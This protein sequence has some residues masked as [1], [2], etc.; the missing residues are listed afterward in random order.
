[1]RRHLQF[2]LSCAVATLA[3]PPVT[4]LAAPEE[5]IPAAYFCVRTHKPHKGAVRIV[6]ADASC[7]PEEKRYIVAGATGPAGSRGATGATGA[8]GAPGDDGAT[9]ATG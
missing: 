9:G 1:M 7:R 3:V 6:R 4:A 8:S 2:M 5:T